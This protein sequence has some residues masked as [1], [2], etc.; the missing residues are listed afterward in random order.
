MKIGVSES[1]LTN[2]SLLNSIVKRNSS[3]NLQC[4]TADII[5]PLSIVSSVICHGLFEVLEME[6]SVNG[7]WEAI[8]T[9]LYCRQSLFTESNIW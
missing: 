7:F 6:G 3:N 5:F 1:L 2:E 9:G 4:W 8:Y